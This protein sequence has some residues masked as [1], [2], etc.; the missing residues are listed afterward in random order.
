MTHDWEHVL[1]G[2]NC[3]KIGSGATPRGG[4]A[5]YVDTGVAL[6]RSQNVYNG[7]FSDEGLAYIG[8]KHAEQL[9]GVTV[10]E[11]DVLLNITGDSV[12]RSCR[13]PSSVLPARVNQH[14]ALIRPKPDDF[15]SR[16]LSHFLV[17]PQMQK[18][19]LSL[20]GTGGTRKALTKEMIQRFQVPKPP[21]AVQRDIAEVLSRY[22]E[23]IENNRKRIALLEEAA[24]L[25]YREWFVHLRFPLHEHVT[26]VDGVPH[27][28]AYS[29]VGSVIELRYGKA[30]KAEDRVAGDFDVYGS[31]GVVGT[32]K[33]AL[34]PGPAIIVGRKGNV[35]SIFWSPS[36]FWPIDTVYYVPKEQCDLWL[37]FALPLA[38][39]QNTDGGVPG[40]NRD[41]AYSRKLLCPTT[42]IRQLFNE[43]VQPMFRQVTVLQTTNR[44]LAEARDLLLPRLMN[45][46]IAV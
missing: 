1:L 29:A 16:Y 19:M 30:L 12:A 41:F 2:P 5:V 13:V 27:G 46:E 34:T 8:D 31:S 10:E 7:K 14:V 35:G 44:K 18:V 32:H 20:A 21:L 6:I 39:F 38:G 37:Y 25:L 17:S 11:G 15:D 4:E 22:E 40:L 45:G 3:T 42:Q 9:A 26:C 36:D 28:W 23:L 33:A 43:A 24:R